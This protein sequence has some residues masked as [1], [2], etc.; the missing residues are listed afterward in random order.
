M[1][2]KYYCFFL[3]FLPF[4]LVPQKAEPQKTY[5]KKIE[6]FGNINIDSLLFYAK[7]GQESQNPC[8]KYHGF[9]SEA[10]A[11]YK[12]GDYTKAET[13]CIAVLK[14]LKDKNSLCDKKNK[15]SALNRLF[16]I[17]KNQKKFNEAFY[18]LKEEQKVIEK[19]Q[20]K[21]TQYYIWK[22]GVNANMAS[23][24]SI[25]NLDNEAINILTSIDADFSKLKI[26]NNERYYNSV[27]TT[28][29]SVLNMIGNSYYNLSNDS[30]T[31]FLDSS[32]LYYKKAYDVTQ[33][34]SPLHKNSKAL[35]HFRVA[36]ILI[37]KKEF[38]EA[39]SILRCTKCNKNTTQT[40]QDI[41][42]L[43]AVIYHHLKNSDSVFF[44]SYNFLKSPK[45]T[46]STKKNK[47][48]IY[49]LLT[50]EYNTL[51]KA[52][53]AYKYAELELKELTELTNS[54]SEINKTHY[55][56]DVNK[57]KAKN[58]ANT[59]KELLARYKLIFLFSIAFM[60]LSYWIYYSYKKK[61]ALALQ[62]K[63]I[64]DKFEA[65]L[66]PSKKEYPIEKELEIKILNRLQEVEDACLFLSKDYSLN[67]LAK[68]LET[69]TSYLS[70]IINKNMKLTFKQ[71]LTTLRINYL[72]TKLN[73]EK[74]YRR[75][76]IQ[77]LAEEIGYTNASA[78][79]RAFKKHMSTT[80]SA[81]ISS[82]EEKA[83]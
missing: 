62:Y 56:Y 71:Y 80:P 14:K 22:W 50:K 47:T 5:F 64:Q 8:I 6:F 21:D 41:H 19:F 82:I 42:L 46:P 81:Y 72:V 73:N 43:K 54:T 58:L 29:S 83:S 69:N 26:A 74:I 13:I 36:K 7:R 61:R 4:L 35:Y 30:I 76:S 38:K 20:K 16:W 3:L 52:D 1:I 17:K 23:I 9:T 49:S 68:K 33:K 28:H 25:L 37:V 65:I 31:Q 34:L 44:Y 66:T 11:W 18:Y 40:N 77:S 75:Y 60:L 45:T 27:L 24:K 53:S 10:S 63:N 39:L 78:F 57:I 70:F 79:T 48:T 12:N 2:K 67:W 59:K 51:K 15:A 32:L 55:L